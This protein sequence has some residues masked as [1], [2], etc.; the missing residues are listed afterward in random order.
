MLIKG[1]SGERSTKDRKW[2]LENV[3]I[4]EQRIFKLKLREHS[5]VLNLPFVCT[6]VFKL[7]RE[8]GI[9][10]AVLCAKLRNEWITEK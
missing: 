7:C 8:H 1:T 4:V 3:G 6:N 2:R 9:I 10:T 5:L